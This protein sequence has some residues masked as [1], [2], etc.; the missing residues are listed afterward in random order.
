MPSSVLVPPVLLLQ[1]LELAALRNLVLILL[2]PLVVLLWQLQLK[3]CAKILQLEPKNSAK[4]H[5]TQKIPE[6]GTE[7]YVNSHQNKPRHV[8][9]WKRKISWPQQYVI[10]Q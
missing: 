10:L 8:G 5:R 1:I 7:N 3:L 2:D 9:M 6:I 4:H